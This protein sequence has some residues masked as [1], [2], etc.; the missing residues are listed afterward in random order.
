MRDFGIDREEDAFYRHLPRAENLTFK[1]ELVSIVPLVLFFLLLAGGL[2]YLGILNFSVYQAQA[3]RNRVARIHLDPPRGEIV[4]R[5]GN[6]LAVNHAGY[7]C[8]FITSDELEQDLLDLQ[9][10]CDY[11]GMST[12]QLENVLESRREA[13]SQR[14]LASELWAAGRGSLGARSILVK[15]DLNQVE[16]TGILER[17]T[18]YPSTYLERAYRRS[19]PAGASTAQLIGY[20]GPIS[21]SELD[22]WETLGYRISNIVGKAGL[23]RQYDNIL[24]GRSG[25]RLVAVDARGHIIGDAEMVPAVVP[26]N[27]AVVIADG[28]VHIY[29]SE[30]PPQVNEDWQVFTNP[31]EIVQVNGQVIMRPSI[32]PPTGGTTLRLTIDLDIQR[33]I[34]DI[35]GDHVGGVVALNPRDGSI[36]AMVSQPG[37][38][39]N[40]FAPGGTDPEGWQAILDDPNFPLLNRPVQNAYVPGSVFK[41][42]TALIAAEEGFT[43]HTWTCEGSLEVGNRTFRCWN[44]GGHGTV[45]FTEAM[46]ESC[47]VAFWEMAQELGHVRIQEMAERLGLGSQLGVDLPDERSGL[48]PDE[49]WK[50]GRFDERWFTGDTMNMAI[51]QGFVQLTIL[52]V[53]EMTAIAANGGFLVPPHINRLLTPSSGNIERLDIDQ[54]DLN[55]V[56]RGLRRCVTTGTGRGCNLDWIQIAGKTGTADDPPREDPH[57]WFTSFAPYSDPALVIVVFCENGGHGDEKAVPLARRIWECESVRAYLEEMSAI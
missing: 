1:R 29:D 13:G 31:G 37:Y 34:D 51:G 50:L 12:E 5:H 21:E 18:T 10:L 2:G 14:S 56:Q 26:D 3:A 23:E 4:D 7:D 48:I 42:V 27:G 43:N 41:I 20:V 49:E 52:Q 36:L 35:L 38:D 45:D 6:P 15:R 24:R 9:T 57:S 8:Y 53:A 47:D 55:A 39:P 16:V 28:E 17:R 44:L 46:A 30:E 54:Q 33:D 22:Q 40:I 25:E 32:I 19:Y 11:L